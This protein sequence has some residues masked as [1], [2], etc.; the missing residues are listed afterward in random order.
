MSTKNKL[1]RQKRRLTKQYSDVYKRQAVLYTLER[2]KGCRL[3]RFFEAK[4]LCSVRWS[5]QI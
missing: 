1:R 5:R 2:M 4:R 3:K